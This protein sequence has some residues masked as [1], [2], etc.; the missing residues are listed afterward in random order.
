VSVAATKIV[1]IRAATIHDTYTGHQGVEH[2]AV[3]VL[4][5]GARVIGPEAAAEIIAAFLSATVSNEE[6]HVRRR[7]KVDEIERTGGMM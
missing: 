2:D 5:L 7:A 6:R 1:G 4:C 3:N